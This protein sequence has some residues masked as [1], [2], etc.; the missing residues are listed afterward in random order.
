MNI[1]RYYDAPSFGD[2]LV[3]GLKV[4]IFLTFLAVAW[5]LWNK[6]TSFDDH[7]EMFEK[8]NYPFAIVRSGMVLGQ[9]IAML[10]LL[11]YKSSPWWASVL[12]QLGFSLWVLVLFAVLRPIL[13]RLV[14][15]GRSRVDN[16]REAVLAIALVQAAFYIA[17]GLIIGAALSGSAPSV[18]TGLWATFIF[19]FLGLGSLLVTYWVLGGL[20]VFRWKLQYST[21]ENPQYGRT[22]LNNA[23]REGNGAAAFLSAGMVLGLGLALRNAIAGDFAGWAVGVLGF[24]MVYLAAVVALC[25]SVLVL[26][27]LV[28]T[29]ATIQDVVCEDRMV[30]AA[31]IG[32]LIVAAALGATA[33]VV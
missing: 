13:E 2:Y 18:A 3:G 7:E 15:R 26:D 6:L 32:V 25:I 24:I 29:N 30:P 17:N 20:P 5:G 23:V 28:V 22:T 9:A 11:A 8:G 27:K 33:L 14:K 31:V 4:L 12:W 19:T 10:P 16:I 21:V 1:G